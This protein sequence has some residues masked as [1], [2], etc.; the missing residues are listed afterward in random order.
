LYN[1]NKIKEFINEIG[2][3][4]SFQFQEFKSRLIKMNAYVDEADQNLKNSET[5]I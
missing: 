4:S 5:D 1:L 3:G 2:L